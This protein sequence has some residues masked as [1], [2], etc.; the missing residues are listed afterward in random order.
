MTKAMIGLVTSERELDSEAKRPQIENFLTGYCHRL[1]DGEADDWP[2][3]F[4]ID[5]SYE[6]TTRENV[7]AKHPIG[8]MLC[9]GR[10]MMADRIL[11]M[12]T[13]NIFES[14]VYCHVIGR[15]EILGAEAEV[16]DVRS[17][18]I[19]HRTMYDG[20]SDLFAT[21]KYLDLISFASGAPLFKRRQVVL[22]SRRI[23]T[24]LVMPL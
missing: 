7:A 18:F 9:E 13:A 6:I 22:D 23:D 17:N 5:G 10:G 12:K 20:R 24:L 4:T 14:H 2:T 21:G 15:P 16:F 8:I 19:I 3:L 1:D 11:A